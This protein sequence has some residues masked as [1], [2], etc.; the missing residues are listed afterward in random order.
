MKPICQ[1][2]ETYMSTLNRKSIFRYY[3]F[4]NLIR[5]AKQEYDRS[6]FQRILKFQY[7]KMNQIITR[8]KFFYAVTNTF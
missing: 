1:R 6:E 3:L 8:C 5:K 4:K 7:L 2:C